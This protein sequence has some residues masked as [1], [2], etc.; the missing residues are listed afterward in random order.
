MNFNS[1]LSSNDNDNPRTRCES[2]QLLFNVILC[3][4]LIW[5]LLNMRTWLFRCWNPLNLLLCNF[6]K[7]KFYQAIN[8]ILII[9]SKWRNEEAQQVHEAAKD[10]AYPIFECV[11]A[12]EEATGIQIGDS[13]QIV[14]KT[15]DYQG[16]KPGQESG[17]P[18][19]TNNA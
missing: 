13:S 4:K 6:L 15:Y 1:T 3:R 16:P 2:R 10:M 19:F 8:P 5:F 9:P 14:D 11:S 12:I 7:N 17:V 18:Q